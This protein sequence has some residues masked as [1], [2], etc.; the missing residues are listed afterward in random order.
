MREVR[1]SEAKWSARYFDRKIT[2]SRIGKRSIEIPQKVEVTLEPGN[3]LRVKGPKGEMSR[4]MPDRIEIRIDNE[5]GKVEFVN[6]GDKP[7]NRKYHGLARALAFNMINGVS[8]GW[9]KHLKVIGIGYSVNVKG[10]QLE[11]N[12]G[13][14]NPRVLDIPEGIE[15]RAERSKEPNTTDLW[16]SGIDKEVLGHFASVIRIQRPPEP[17]KGKGVRYADE[18]VR[19]K[20]GKTA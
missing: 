11:L 19:R 1:V 3:V 17:Y 4:T 2:M 10:N 18:Y 7:Q 9:E 20:A 5:A 13:Y 6:I 16:V 15:V 14:S 8:E 12:L